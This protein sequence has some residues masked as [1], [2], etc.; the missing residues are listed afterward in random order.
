MNEYERIWERVIK[1]WHEKISIRAAAYTWISLLHKRKL[2]KY[3]HS[4]TTF[5]RGNLI[6]THNGPQSLYQTNVP[7]RIFFHS[8]FIEISFRLWPVL[9]L[10]QRLR[11]PSLRLRLPLPLSAKAFDRKWPEPP[12]ADRDAW[13]RWGVVPA[14]DGE[15]D[16]TVSTRGPE[17]RRLRNWWRWRRRNR[18]SRLE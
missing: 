14:A 16:S 2:Q 3:V 8:R 4:K 17:A 7:L 15:F 6:F 10:L 5:E 11:R 9:R 12:P 1:E 13:R 18:A